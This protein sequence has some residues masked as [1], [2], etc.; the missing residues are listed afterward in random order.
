[1]ARELPPGPL[2]HAACARGG[3]DNWQVRVDAVAGREG[4][5]GGVQQ[6]VAHLRARVHADGH[7]VGASLFSQA[8]SVI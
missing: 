4:V 8:L 7:A 3:R 6:E 2:Y 1:M 5:D